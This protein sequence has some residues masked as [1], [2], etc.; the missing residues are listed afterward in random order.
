LLSLLSI[1][2]LSPLT[3]LQHSLL[4]IPCDALKLFGRILSLLRLA[5]SGFACVSFQICSSTCPAIPVYSTHS[6]WR[7][8]PSTTTPPTIHA[9]GRLHY[10][11][12]AHANQATDTQLGSSVRGT[13][14]RAAP[15]KARHGTEP[16]RTLAHSA[17]VTSYAANRTGKRPVGSLHHY[18]DPPNRQK[19]RLATG[20]PNRCPV[21]HW[22]P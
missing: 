2:R 7:H 14:R 1:L 17:Q 21:G 20:D 18:L 16:H 4:F 11:A 6:L 9:L 12:Q 10:R 15:S 19:S 13:E 3:Q 5:P 8:P 22:A